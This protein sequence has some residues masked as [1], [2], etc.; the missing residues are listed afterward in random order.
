V[1]NDFELK[2]FGYDTV[3]IK[4]EVKDENKQNPKKIFLQIFY[5]IYS[6]KKMKLL[7]K[8]I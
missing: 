6:L 2:D 5:Q 3:I 7:K 1:E 4:N 8:I